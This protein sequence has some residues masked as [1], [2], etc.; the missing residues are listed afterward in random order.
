MRENAGDPKPWEK[1][2]NRSNA[3]GK[4]RNKPTWKYDE[5]SELMTVGNL[6]LPPRSLYSDSRTFTHSKERQLNAIVLTATVLD[7]NK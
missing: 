6:L 7:S 2:K 1:T 3:M 5:T 4:R